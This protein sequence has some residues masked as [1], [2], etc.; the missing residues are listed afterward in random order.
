MTRRP[1]RGATNDWVPKP[2]EQPWGRFWVPLLER[3]AERPG[4]RSWALG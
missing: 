2:A 3:C 4:E 1:V